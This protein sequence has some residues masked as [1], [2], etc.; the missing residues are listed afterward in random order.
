[1]VAHIFWS[2]RMGRMASRS[3]NNSTSAT[4]SSSSRRPPRNVFLYHHRL[5][6]LATRKA[7][8]LV[9]SRKY[10]WETHRLQTP[11]GWSQMGAEKILKINNSST[12][13]R[14]L[15]LLLVQNLLILFLK[16]KKKSRR[17]FLWQLVFCPSL[18]R[19]ESFAFFNP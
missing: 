4:S 14:S 5:A 13:T 11:S 18:Q 16:K 17:I 12:K 1:M 6:Q 2:A 10:N 3:Q 8:F 9:R 15:L 7:S 19:R